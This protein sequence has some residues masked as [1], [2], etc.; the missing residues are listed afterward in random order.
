MG[1][2]HDAPTLEELLAAAVRADS[3]DPGAEDRAL[4]A[5]RTARQSGAHRARTR[6][7]DDWRRGPTA[8]SGAR[9]G[10]R[11]PR[12]W[13]ARPSAAWPSR[14]SA[15]SARSAPRTT[16]ATYR[17]P[18]RAHR[19]GP[20][21]I[22][23]PGLGHPGRATASRPHPPTVRRPRGTT[24]PSRQVSRSRS[25]AH[26]TPVRATSRPLR[27]SKPPRT[28]RPPRISRPLRTTRLLR[29]SR[30][31]RISRP[32]R[33]SPARQP[34]LRRNPATTPPRARRTDPA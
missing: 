12:C 19:T 24:R 13:R 32:C 31:P 18:R 26:R 16:A 15:R 27:I 34:H 28:C 6:R 3:L 11:W 14:R 33:A 5:F 21:R 4:A 29:T 25:R 1:E 22:L 30:P 7:R 20:R 10:R 2:R 23:P 9:C 8:G 17:G